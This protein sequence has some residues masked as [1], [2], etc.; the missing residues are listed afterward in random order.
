MITRDKSRFVGF[1]DNIAIIIGNTIIKT[2][3]Y[4]IDSFRIKVILGFLFI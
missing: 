3:F 2:R 4:I 1:I